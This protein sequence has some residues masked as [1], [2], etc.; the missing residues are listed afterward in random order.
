MTTATLKETAWRLG[1]DHGVFYTSERACT[2]FI[3]FSTRAKRTCN[4]L[5]LTKVD[6]ELGLGWYGSWHIC[7][8][9]LLSMYIRLD[10]LISGNSNFTLI[11]DNSGLHITHVLFR[12]NY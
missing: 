5:N 6:A 7:H 4:R 2:A 11:Y 8:G 3:A 12:P 10:A 9:C 1:T